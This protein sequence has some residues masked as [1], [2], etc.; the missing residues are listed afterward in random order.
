M[1]LWPSK[2]FRVNLIKFAGTYFPERVLY[3]VLAF[4]L[5]PGKFFL[6][7]FLLILLLLLLFLLF[8]F[9]LLTLILFPTVNGS[10]KRCFEQTESTAKRWDLLP[11]VYQVGLGFLLIIIFFP[12]TIL[13]LF[14]FCR[15]FMQFNRSHEFAIELVSDTLNRQTFHFLQQQMDNYRSRPTV[16]FCLRGSWVQSQGYVRDGEEEPSSLLDVGQEDAPVYQVRPDLLSP[17]SLTPRA[18]HELLCNLVAMESH[19]EER[20]RE[21]GRS[22]EPWI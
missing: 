13:V 9:L 4:G 18:Y 19:G 2:L 7:L 6:S 22:L 12:L 17:D 5:Q 14:L 15:F 1:A 11:M 10:S 8:L 21:A 3:R 16:V 20:V